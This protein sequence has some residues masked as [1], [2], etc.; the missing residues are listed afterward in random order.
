MQRDARCRGRARELD[1]THVRVT[2]PRVW[3]GFR[4]VCRRCEWLVCVQRDE[5]TT[6]GATW[7]A[8]P[9]KLSSSSSSA[10]FSA[11]PV[12]SYCRRLAS[13]D[14][15]SYARWMSANFS[16]SP[17]L[18]GCSLV[19]RLRYARRIC[20]SRHRPA[21]VTPTSVRVLSPQLRAGSGLRWPHPLS[22]DTAVLKRLENA[23][24]TRTTHVMPSASPTPELSRAGHLAGHLA[25]R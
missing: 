2:R 3:R 8:P 19:I 14:R 7:D 24:V 18:S 1:V 15:T 22:M 12:V 6:A 25:A 23:H 4:W 13:L 21:S 9:P 17:P 16:G 10:V 20:A 11:L 5:W